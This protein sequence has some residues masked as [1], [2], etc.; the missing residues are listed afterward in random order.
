MKTLILEKLKEIE[1]K[2][3]IKVLLAAESGSRAWGF[4]S[5]DS[6]YDV[7]FVYLRQKEDYLR[8]D[9]LQDVIEL[10]INEELDINGWDLQKALRLLYKS[11][12]TLFEWFTSPIVY[13]ETP[14][15]ADF[16]RLMK[17]YF[18][19]KKG[20]QHYVSMAKGNYRD[21]LRGETVKIKKYFY[22]L[23]PLLACYWVL[24]EMT[25]PPVL[26]SELVAAKLP[27]SLKSEVDMLLDLKRNS[28]EI[29]EIL[30]IGSVTEYIEDSLEDINARLNKLEDKKD[31]GWEPLN[32][33]FLSALSK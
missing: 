11:N 14:L 5:P 18:S 9:P 17:G 23:R 33:F 2:N 20:L 26:F 28:P 32:T 24:E 27:A 21:F 6:D 16:R 15:A 3:G 13:M 10:P 12:P 7:R 29:K 31:N 22:A 19:S 30:A 25:P 8:L 4:S 1:K